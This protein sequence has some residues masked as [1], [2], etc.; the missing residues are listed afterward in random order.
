[1]FLSFLSFYLEAPLALE[2]HAE[3][4]LAVPRERAGALQDLLPLWLVRMHELAAAI[5]VQL[6]ASQPRHALLVHAARLWNAE[7]T[8]EV[9]VAAWAHD[10]GLAHLATAVAEDALGLGDLAKS[11][12]ARRRLVG[13]AALGALQK[14]AHAAL[15]RAELLVLLLELVHVDVAPGE[16]AVPLC[17]IRKEMEGGL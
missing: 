14:I 1:M 12:A 3:V 10:R 8:L 17:E 4:A 16:L 11:G 7:L 9:E 6:A 5:A 15:V 2:K 13:L